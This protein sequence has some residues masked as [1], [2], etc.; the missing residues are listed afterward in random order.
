MR[1]KRDGTQTKVWLT[2]DDRRNL[3]RV[4]VSDRNQII[5]DTLQVAPWDCLFLRSRTQN[6]SAIKDSVHVIRSNHLNIPSQRENTVFMGFVC[7]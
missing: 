6:L 5:I 2:S 7:L 3:R 4:A 1:L